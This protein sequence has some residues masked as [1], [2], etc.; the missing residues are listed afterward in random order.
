MHDLHLADKIIK[1]ILEFAREHKLSKVKKVWIEIG[2][3]LEHG[4]MISPENLK[5]NLKLLSNATPAQGAEFEVKKIN[6]ENKYI[7][8]EIEG[9]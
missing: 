4:E 5:F 7:I 1:Q 6:E 2:D 8:Q 9:E 3:I